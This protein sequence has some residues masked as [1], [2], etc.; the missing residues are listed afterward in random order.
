[1]HESFKEGF[2]K[3][4]AALNVAASPITM[5]AKTLVRSQPKNFA[6]K[7]TAGKVTHLPNS[8]FTPGSPARPKPSLASQ[9]LMQPPPPANAAVNRPPM[10]PKSTK[11]PLQGFTGAPSKNTPVAAGPLQG[12][13]DSEAR[14]QFHQRVV[15]RNQQKVPAS[16]QAP[17]ANQL[18]APRQAPVANQ[19]PA[20]R[21]QPRVQEE[22]V[23]KQLPAA[24]EV[25]AQGSARGQ[26]NAEA[27]QQFRQQAQ[28]Q[29]KQLPQSQQ[30]PQKQKQKRSQTPAKVTPLAETAA[31]TSAPVQNTVP[32][33]FVGTTYKTAPAAKPQSRY[34]NQVGQQQAVAQPAATQ[35]PSTPLQFD[36]WDRKALIGGGLLSAG[37]L[38][39]R[40][41]APN[42]QQ[43]QPRYY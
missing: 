3:G 43:Q 9:G 31:Q 11:T 13:A 5:A 18:P 1:M 28:Q 6:V 19:L 26:T 12:Q 8:Q 16:Q 35:Q 40:A 39:G 23:P 42:Q 33:G 32:R 17:V 7:A 34:N 24:G 22:F 30:K 36:E 21:Q 14:N 10:P 25:V 4:A 41:T 20:P 37:A 2:E 27:R 29:P 15:Q 38:A